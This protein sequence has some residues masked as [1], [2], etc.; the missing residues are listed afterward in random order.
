MASWDLLAS[1]KRAGGLGFTDTRVMNK[2]LLA[3]WIFKVE[4]EE[5]NMCS[6]LL[7]KKYLGEKGFFSCR[8]SNCSQ[9]WKGLL[10]IKEDCMR[11]FKYIIG[12][13]R[14]AR[15]WHDV[16][17]LDCPLKVAFPHIFE[18]CNQQDWSVHRVCSQEDEVLSFRRNFGHREEMEYTELLELIGTINLSE[19]K[20]S[21]KWV[22]EKS[23]SFT[24]SSLY[25]ELT[26]TGFANRWLLNVF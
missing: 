17:V 3:K 24:T 14:K 21:V 8:K 7:R 6:H 15:F 11:G 12:D 4:N 22:L 2:C 25:N 1:P 18:I 9:F 20:D 5:D 19:G 26:F 10:D 16:W 23:G 13:G